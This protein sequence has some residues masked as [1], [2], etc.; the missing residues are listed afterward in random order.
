MKSY[1]QLQAEEI[2]RQIDEGL[3]SGK[4]RITE[5]SRLAKLADE[6]LRPQYLNKYIAYQ[7]IWNGDTSLNRIVLAAGKTQ[8]EMFT[9]LKTAKRDNPELQI[10][11]RRVMPPL[12]ESMNEEQETPT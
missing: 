7:D 9:A 5:R 12:E 1:R 10:H 4:L 11:Y 6:G 2:T 8:Q 3:A